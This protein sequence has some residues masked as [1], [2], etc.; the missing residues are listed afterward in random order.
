M[1]SYLVSLYMKDKQICRSLA[2]GA[3][4]SSNDSCCESDLPTQFIVG[5]EIDQV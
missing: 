3:L 1:F 5:G 2:S 4:C